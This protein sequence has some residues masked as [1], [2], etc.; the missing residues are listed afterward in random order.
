[1]DMEEKIAVL[2]LAG[3]AVR[4]YADKYEWVHRNE[5]GCREYLGRDTFSTPESAWDSA[6]KFIRGDNEQEIDHE[7]W[8]TK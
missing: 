1:M 3:F 7:V 4:S 5:I 8:S 2:K 6:W